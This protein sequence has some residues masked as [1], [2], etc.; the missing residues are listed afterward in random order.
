VW[1]KDWKIELNEMSLI[2]ER[3]IEFSLHSEL[4]RQKCR[5]GSGWCDSRSV[6]VQFD[7]NLATSVAA[8]SG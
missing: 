2:D 3:E 1:Y 6:N 4:V 7:F 5:W 8:G